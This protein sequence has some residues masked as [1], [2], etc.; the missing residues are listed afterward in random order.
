MGQKSIL[1][2]MISCHL[3]V[4]QK[5]IWKLESGKRDWLEKEDAVDRD[6]HLEAELGG[7]F[8]A[9]LAILLE[10][11]GGGNYSLTSYK[12][13]KGPSVVARV[14]SPRLSA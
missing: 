1:L 9:P 14:R 8:H 10:T 12:V 13:I 11:L 5:R 6:S 2:E 3:Q 7:C 4:S